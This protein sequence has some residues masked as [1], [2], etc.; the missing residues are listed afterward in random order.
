MRSSSTFNLTL[1]FHRE[2][3]K[4]DVET[5]REKYYE[6]QTAASNLG[7]ASK[8]ASDYLKSGEFECAIS[9]LVAA[10][11]P[12]FTYNDS[13][14]S[15]ESVLNYPHII[16]HRPLSSETELSPSDIYADIYRTAGLAYYGQNKHNLA[17]KYLCK[18]LEF[19]AKD[20][21]GYS[22][23]AAIH[24]E[25]GLVYKAAGNH[26]EAIADHLHALALS[27]TGPKVYASKKEIFEAI[28]QI[29]DSAKKISLLKQGIDEHTALGKLLRV[30]QGWRKCR[31]S[32]G[33]LAHFQA[34]LKKEEQKQQAQKELE[35]CRKDYHTQPQIG[36]GTASITHVS[37]LKNNNTGNDNAENKLLSEKTDEL[38]S[39]L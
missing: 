3:Y 11:R 29:E 12:S 36:T 14:R 8:E 31:L 27:S 20:P 24:A 32:S 28:C 37:I 26:E 22:K 7:R 39:N 2:S 4:R 17:V 1:E 33:T 38:L 10:L 15:P 6:Y 34:E 18:A 13:S 19:N 23:E 9:R 21:Q 30:K 35:E 25:R 16:K 5:F